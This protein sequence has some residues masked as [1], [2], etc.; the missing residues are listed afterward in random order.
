[1][2]FTTLALP[3]WVVAAGWIVS[4]PSV[5]FA[6]VMTPWR[7]LREDAAAHVWCAGALILTILWTVPL[8]LGGMPLHLLGLAAYAVLAGP[9]AAL[10]GCASALAIALSFSGGPWQ[11]AGIALAVLGV[12]P[13]AA[14]MVAVHLTRALL[15]PIPVVRALACGWSAGALSCAAALLARAVVLTTAPNAPW[16]GN[17]L[18]AVIVCLGCA[19][20]TLTGTVLVVAALIEPSALRAATGG[21]RPVSRSI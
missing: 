8:S 19:E 7:G 10:V 3:G 11:N 9:A 4:V 20:A 1:M 2:E 13:I 5:L 21:T 17:E 18:F 14:T 16:D 12:G 6:L 15:A